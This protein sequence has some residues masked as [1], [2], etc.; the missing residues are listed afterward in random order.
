MRYHKSEMLGDWRGQVEIAPARIVEE[1]G[2]H[3]VAY[4]VGAET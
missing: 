4:Y 2:R 3:A 1:S